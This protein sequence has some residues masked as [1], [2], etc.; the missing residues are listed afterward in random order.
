[1]PERGDVWLEQPSRGLIGHE[2]QGQ[3]P[4]V[5]VSG[6]GINAGPWP[7]VIV[8][9]LSTRDR[10]IPLHVRITPPDGGVRTSSVVL[11]E[12]IHAADRER[13]V[14]HWGRVSSAT[15]RE[16]KTDSRIVLDLA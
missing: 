13:L 3:R 6:D 5:V 11:V 2:Q 16:S 9:P 10:G 15:M 4:V 1:L 8:V 12:Q 7:L 14:E